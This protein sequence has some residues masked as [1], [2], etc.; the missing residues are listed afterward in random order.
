[1]H[2]EDELAPKDRLAC[3]TWGGSNRQPHGMCYFPACSSQEHQPESCSDEEQQQEPCSS[4]EQ[5]HQETCSNQDQQLQQQQQEAEEE[6]EEEAWGNAKELVRLD[7]VALLS[8]MHQWMAAGSTIEQCV[9]A[10]YA[11]LPVQQQLLATGNLIQASQRSGMKAVEIAQ[12]L[13]STGLAMCSFA[14]PCMC[15]NSGCN[16]LAGLSELAAVSGRSCIC[17]G[18]RVARYCGRACQRA[19]WKQHKPVCGALSA[20][21]AAVAAA[22]T[23]V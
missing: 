18:C 19:A 14:V 13:L 8:V 3:I 12:Q 4:Q 17:G 23:T 21:A 9:A 10:G 15:N 22:G 16:N 2:Q 7:Q 6:Q 20:A 1:M 11:P 5:Q